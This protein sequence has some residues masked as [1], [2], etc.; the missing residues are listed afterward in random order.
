M[1]HHFDDFRRGH[2]GG[3]RDDVA[4]FNVRIAEHVGELDRIHRHDLFG[5]GE[6]NAVA[7]D[8][9]V[10]QVELGNRFAVEFGHCAIDNANR[11]FGIVRLSIA[12]K[13]SSIH[14]LTKPS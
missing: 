10:N 7:C 9:V 12:I 13:P 1:R 8:K 11:G 3:E 4:A 2:R 5:P 6:I 14:S